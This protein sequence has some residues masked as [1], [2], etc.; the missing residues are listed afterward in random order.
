MALLDG[1]WRFHPGDDPHWA[2]P[3]F[4]ESTWAPISSEKS[5]S[6]QGYENMSGLAWYRVKV[7]VPEDQKALSLYVPVPRRN[8]RRRALAPVAVSSP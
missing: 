8:R 4:D 1:L 7:F 5:W 3:G 2:D 6:D